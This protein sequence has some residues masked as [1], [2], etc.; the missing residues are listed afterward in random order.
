MRGA[1]CLGIPVVDGTVITATY[2][3][4]RL[5]G[6]TPFAGAAVTVHAAVAA[7]GLLTTDDLDH[8]CRLQARRF[9]LQSH[10]PTRTWRPRP[11]GLLWSASGMLL[12]LA[13][14]IASLGFWLPSLAGVWLLALRPWMLARASQPLPPPP[15]TET[16]SLTVRRV[17]HQGIASLREVIARNLE[18]NLAYAEAYEVSTRLG[19]PEAADLYTRLLQDPRPAALGPDEG[20]WLPDATRRREALTADPLLDEEVPARPEDDPDTVETEILDAD[21]ELPDQS[22]P[23]E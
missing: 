22:E 16:P 12:G 7:D 15:P 6:A 5:L 14:I 10:P 23:D 4:R 21:F 9:L 11:A 17:T 13:L 2:G 3:T 18:D 8:A 20:I 1:T 19:I